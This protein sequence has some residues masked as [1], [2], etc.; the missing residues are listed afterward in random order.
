MIEPITK[1]TRT[2]VAS[3]CRYSAMPPHTPATTLFVLLRSR[4]VDMDHPF[5]Q[6]VPGRDRERRDETQRNDGLLHQ[7]GESARGH[8]DHREQSQC[9]VEEV[10]GEGREK[11]R[12]RRDLLQRQL[13][14]IPKHDRHAIE[15][16]KAGDRGA[17]AFALL[18]RH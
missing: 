9:E 2:S 13:A 12:D 15:L 7:V 8:R 17:Y 16:R 10:R 11:D 1:K 3:T 18:A 4:R 6:L 5:T 14:E